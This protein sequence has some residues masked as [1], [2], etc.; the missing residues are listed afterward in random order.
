MNKLRKK[1]VRQL[2]IPS[3]IFGIAFVIIWTQIPELPQEHEL[4]PEGW[5]LPDPRVV[6]S[7][8]LLMYYLFAVVRT[9]I[10]PKKKMMELQKEDEK[11]PYQ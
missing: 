1:Q 8:M 7:L 2:L 3:I 4:V 11:E 9:F 6:G 5:S 10:V